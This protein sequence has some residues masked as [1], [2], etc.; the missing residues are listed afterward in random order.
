MKKILKKVL[1]NRLVAFGLILAVELV[2][3]VI[4]VTRLASYSTMISVIFP[5]RL[6][7]QISRLLMY[8]VFG[9]LQI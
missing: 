6:K 3:L 9:K 5:K 7:H 1:Q 2:W 8:H 4:F